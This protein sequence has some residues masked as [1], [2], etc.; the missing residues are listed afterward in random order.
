VFIAGVTNPIFK[1]SPTWDLLL[2]ISTGSV[3]VAR[4]IYSTYPVSAGI[5]LGLGVP[6]MVWTATFNTETSLGS[7]EDIIR[8]ANV[9]DGV[10]ADFTKA[11][12]SAGMYF[13]HP[14]CCDESLFDNT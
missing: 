3:R 11:D 13:P 2:D 9:K 6:N 1:S 4:D 14:L 8:S 7:E 12:N 5:P 10:K